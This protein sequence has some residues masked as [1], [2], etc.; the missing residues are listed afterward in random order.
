MLEY[1]YQN[2]LTS[3]KACEHLPCGAVPLELQFSL[4]YNMYEWELVQSGDVG[5][6]MSGPLVFPTP[7]ATDPKKWYKETAPRSYGICNE[8]VEPID[9]DWNANGSPT[10]VCSRTSDEFY[11]ATVRC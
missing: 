5:I 1:Q 8:R 6:V 10:Y 11:S 9:H 4:Y 3:T 7:T 2:L